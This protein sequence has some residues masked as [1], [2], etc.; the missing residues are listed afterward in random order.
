VLAA[1]KH[2]Y[3][4]NFHMCYLCVVKV[5]KNAI[6]SSNVYVTMDVYHHCNRKK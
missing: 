1:N 4:V 6:D 3:F 2:W 5:A